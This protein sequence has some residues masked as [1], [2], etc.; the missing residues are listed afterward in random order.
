MRTKCSVCGCVIETEFG[1]VEPAEHL[2]A[3]GTE[4]DPRSPGDHDNICDVCD[5]S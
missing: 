4:D 5:Y 1:A 3:E 2:D